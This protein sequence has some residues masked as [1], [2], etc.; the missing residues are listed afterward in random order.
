MLVIAILGTLVWFALVFCVACVRELAETL[1]DCWGRD[2][3]CRSRVA[4]GRARTRIHWFL[5]SA[6][7][8]VF[9]VCGCTSFELPY[10]IGARLHMR[11]FQPSS[12]AW[13]D[14]LAVE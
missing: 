9:V 3:R 13:R 1:A 10:L 7:I 14:S 12:W 11:V 6:C 5:M 2:G 8:P 4:N